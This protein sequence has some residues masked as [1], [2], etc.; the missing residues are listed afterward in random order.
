M[1]YAVTLFI[2]CLVLSP[3]AR[4]TTP[5]CLGEFASLASGAPDGVELTA[6]TYQELLDTLGGKLSPETLRKMRNAED[7]FAVPEQDGADLGALRK[8]LG[9][10]RKLLVE[11]GWMGDVYVN[12]IR[13]SLDRRIAKI[14]AAGT[15]VEAQVNDTWKEFELPYNN[16]NSQYTVT[17]DG[18]GLMVVHMT[19][20][21]PADKGWNTS[22]FRL[23][24]PGEPIS[25]SGGVGY[26]SD[27]MFSADGK[28]L[29]FALGNYELKK[30]PFENGTANWEKAETIGTPDGSGWLRMMQPVNAPYFF[31][32]V[33]GGYVYRFD[34]NTNERILLELQPH[35]KIPK[36]LTNVPH[37]DVFG[38]GQEFFATADGK[39]IFYR[40]ERNYGVFDNRIVKFD[41]LAD[42]NLRPV[43]EFEAFPN[44]EST[45]N[46]LRV[47]PEGNVQ[48]VR[49]NKFYE[50]VGG[51]VKGTPK[52][53]FTPP[54][55]DP[56]LGPL[57]N[58]Y[59]Q[60]RPGHNE[61]SVTYSDKNHTRYV[62]QLVD[63]EQGRLLAEFDL[64]KGTYGFQFSPDGKRMLV[65]NSK[66]KKLEVL[67]PARRAINE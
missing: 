6:S 56:K 48:Y 11:K 23:D 2:A 32:G 64:P 16:G 3:E 29:V 31:A 49:A 25:Q 28:F 58:A 30:V 7:V 8:R 43:Q 41:I 47:T 65:S 42:G 38:Q 36:H 59:Y 50:H 40:I 22:F 66:K 26:H 35:L 37:L 46:S 57:E 52:F 33:H 21:H 20:G 60:H 62:V 17:P 44:N 53:S 61:I 67:N 27:P 18:K 13:A 10:F 15:Q 45:S 1:R 24:G 4:A 54:P 63:K 12:G 19:N 51:S 39:S 14:D 55:P 5:R 9:E 34:L